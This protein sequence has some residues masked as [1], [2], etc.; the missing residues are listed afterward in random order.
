MPQSGARRHQGFSRKP[1][2]KQLGALSRIAASRRSSPIGCA[3]SGVEISSERSRTTV[4]GQPTSHARPAAQGRQQPADML[5]AKAATGHTVRG[6][7]GLLLNDGTILVGDAQGAYIESGYRPHL[8]WRTMKRYTHRRRN[9]PPHPS[10]LPHAGEAVI[11][12][13]LTPAGTRSPP[14]PTA[15]PAAADSSPQPHSAPPAQRSAG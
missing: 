7:E 13:L 5:T 6:A 10:P 12:P 11:C 2:V 15:A 3:G 8:A 1:C 4:S 9:N 14:P